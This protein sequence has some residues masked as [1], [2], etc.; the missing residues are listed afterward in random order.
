MVDEG[1]ILWILLR[2]PAH[3]ELAPGG[4]DGFLVL[5]EPAVLLHP[6][7]VPEHL[8]L[9]ELSAAGRPGIGSICRGH[10]RTELPG[11]LDLLL[12]LRTQPGN[13]IITKN[14]GT[15][16]A[17]VVP[18]VTDYA[19]HRHGLPPLLLGNRS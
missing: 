5:V 17:T 6:S 19:D 15:C 9:V 13:V 12:L 11:G 16:A 8:L 3:G 4:D 7:D 1:Q 18:T 10:V 14:V 2:Q